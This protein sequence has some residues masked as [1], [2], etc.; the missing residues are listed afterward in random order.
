MLDLFKMKIEQFENF[1]CKSGQNAKENWNLLD[2]AKNHHVFLHLSSF[3]SGYVILEY[4][5]DS[6]LSQFMLHTAAQI[7]K[8]NTKYK[9]MKNIK[10]DWC[11]CD[12]L[13]KGDMIGEVYFKSNK[14][15][16]QI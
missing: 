1:I 7:C 12:N 11:R 14:K 16:N 3:P 2:Q 10:I 5:E 15:V 4:D 9:K 13:K 8:N 6:K